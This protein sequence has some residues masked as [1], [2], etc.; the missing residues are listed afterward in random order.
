MAP[1]DYY[2]VLGVARNSSAEEIK[3]AYRRLALKHHPDRNPGDKSA[4]DKF[5]EI[6]QAYE[7]LSDPKK[8]TL[9]DQYGHAGVGQGGQ[10]PFAGRPGAGGQQDFGDIFGDIFENFFGGEGGPGGGRGR[11]GQRGS[12]L[13]YELEDDLEQAFHGVEMP[14][15]FPR[16]E[17]CKSCAGQGASPGTGRKSCPRCAGAGRIQFS[18]GFFS[19]SQTCP[20]CAGQGSVISSPCKD[21]KGQG[22]KRGM[23]KL[24]IKIPPGVQAGTTLRVGEEGEPGPQGGP[25]G[26]LYVVLKVKDHPQFHR[27]GDDLV[28]EKPLSFPQAALGCVLEVPTIDGQKARIRV[29]PG[30]QTGTVFRIKEHGMPRL[31]TKVK[32]D[33]LVRVRVEVPR[34]LSPK[35]KELIKDLAATMGVDVEASGGLFKKL[36]E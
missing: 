35:Q 32:G 9:Y 25:A 10:G 1:I 13:K 22:R 4:E 16:W 15:N 34:T 14:V 18:Q 30:T 21:C 12:D 8:K 24:K 5:K 17:N 28:Y 26:D 20:E 7:V 6:N 11:R 33:L 27:E 29:N 3:A 19:L 23:A 2:T 31:S 36:F